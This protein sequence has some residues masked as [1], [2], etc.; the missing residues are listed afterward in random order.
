MVQMIKKIFYMGVGAAS[1]LAE[2]LDKLASRGEAYLDNKSL[3][4]VDI[5]VEADVVEVES[6]ETAVSTD[7][8]TKISGIGPTFAKRLKEAGITTYAALA[9]LTPDQAKEITH[10]ADWQADPQEWISQAQAF[11]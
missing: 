11:A 7:D 3:E 8:L 6:A 1:L 2:A 4:L 10:A 5:E 9:N